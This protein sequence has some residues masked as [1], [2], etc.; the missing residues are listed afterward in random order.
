MQQQNQ[1]KTALLNLTSR[2]FLLTVAG[3]ALVTMYPEN[4][5]QIV[6]LIVAFISAEG[7]GDVVQ[8][9]QLG[10]VQKASVEQTTAKIESGLLDPETVDK[11]R[12]VPGDTVQ[13]NI[14]M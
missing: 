8:R 7:V 13:P 2:K 10:N 6:T 4:A 9:Y 12:V 14:T 1:I 5:P 3:I 11:N